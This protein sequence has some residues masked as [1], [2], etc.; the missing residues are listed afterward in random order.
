MKTRSLKAMLLLV[1]VMLL[2]LNT[3][4][5]GVGDKFSKFVDSDKSNYQGLYIILGVVAASLV[6]YV[7]VNHYSK[8]EE[9]VKR[10]TGAHHHHHHHRK[11]HHHHRVIKKTS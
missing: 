11:H 2:N 7:I 8:D 5:A 9:N 4:L 6:T 10:G 1:G 3:A